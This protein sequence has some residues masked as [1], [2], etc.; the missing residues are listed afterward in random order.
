MEGGGRDL[1]QSTMPPFACRDR[2][3]LQKPESG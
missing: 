3:K 2:G 1:F